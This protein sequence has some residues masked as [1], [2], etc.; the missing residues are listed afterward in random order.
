MD[1]EAFI[2]AQNYPILQKWIMDKDGTQIR[3]A[4]RIVR[5]QQF[6]SWYKSNPKGTFD[7][8]IS[9][10]KQKRLEYVNSP[11]YQIQVLQN[12]LENAIIENDEYQ[13]S[14]KEKNE[15]IE[16]LSER[17]FLYNVSLVSI[18]ILLTL[19]ILYIK[20]SSISIFLKSIWT[21]KKNK[22]NIQK[23]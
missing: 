11:Q 5:T 12:Q 15:E 17:I 2:E 1:V 20:R 4:L 18:F 14:I 23:S 13:K 8:Y 9:Y 19:T 3:E 6:Q 22:K 21:T 10:L 7:Q 16:S